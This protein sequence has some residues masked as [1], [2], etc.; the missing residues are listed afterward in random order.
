MTRK[1]MNLRVFRRAVATRV[2]QPRFEPWFAMH[3]NRGTLPE[4]LKGM[5]LTDVYDSIARLCAPFTI[6]RPALS[7][8]CLTVQ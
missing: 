2:F 8:P 7:N 1:E 6:H 4:Q 3:S 5:S